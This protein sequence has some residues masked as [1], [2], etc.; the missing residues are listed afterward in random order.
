MPQ[1]LDNLASGFARHELRWRSAKLVTALSGAG[2]ALLE[3]EGKEGK[4][5]KKR[6]RS[7]EVMEGKGG[8]EAVPPRNLANLLTAVAKLSSTVKG[9]CDGT[10][11]FS[12]AAARDMI[13]PG[14]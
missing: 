6:N 2:V 4:E 9:S 3:G 7:K 12:A 5:G 8:K 11:E 10:R 14:E 13:T 1:D